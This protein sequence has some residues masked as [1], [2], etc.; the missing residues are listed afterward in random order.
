MFFPDVEI[1]SPQESAGR[2]EKYVSD[3]VMDHPRVPAQA[4]KQLCDDSCHAFHPHRGDRIGVVVLDEKMSGVM[5]SDLTE[6]LY[7][8]FRA[9]V[10]D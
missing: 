4:L 3:H 10:E 7:D 1:P 8:A 2:F 5:P 6:E 9:L